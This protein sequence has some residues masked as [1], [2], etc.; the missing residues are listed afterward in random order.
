MART[1]STR[2]VRTARAH[3]FAPP[4]EPRDH[5]LRPP[6]SEVPRRGRRPRGADAGVRPVPRLPPVLQVLQRRS[7]RSS[8]SSTATTTRT[9]PTLPRR[10]GPGRGRV[11]PVQALLRQLPVHPRPERVGDR[12]PAPH[13]AGRR[14]APRRRRGLR[15]APRDRQRDGSHRPARQAELTRRAGRE[16]RS[17]AS[18]AAWSAGPSMARTAGISSERLLP[19]FTRQRFTTWF[20][21]APQGAHGAVPG[22]GDRLPDVPRRVPGA[23]GRATTS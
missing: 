22:A 2:R 1:G 23:G 18:A 10:A 14:H 16:Q 11:L 3:W 15:Q 8:S 20:K 9:P 19:P 13:A 17:P 4:T 6:P 5:H 12:L 7:R 21:Q